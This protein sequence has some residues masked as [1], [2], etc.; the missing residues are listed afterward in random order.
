MT[1]EELRL[2]YYVYRDE[3]PETPSAETADGYVHLWVTVQ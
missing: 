1:G 3:V 2:T